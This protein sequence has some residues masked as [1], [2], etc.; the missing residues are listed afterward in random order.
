MR[1]LGIGKDNDLGSLYLRLM[2][3]GHEVKVFIE[4]E[5]SAETL[6]GMVDRVADWSAELAWLRAAGRDGAILFEAT[7]YGPVAEQLRH[8]GFQIIGSSI[9]GDRLEED[10][11]F[12]QQIMRATGM[13]V[14]ESHAF[15]SFDDGIAFVRERPARYVLKL[16]GS[17]LASGHT[18]PSELADGR[19][20]IAM[21]EWHSHRWVTERPSF[22]LMDLLDGVEVGVGAYFNGE[23]FLRPACMDWE[24][25]RFFPGD[26][27]E[28]TGEMGTL[29]TY[30]ARTR[31]STRRWGGWS[32]GS[33]RPA[34]SATSTS[35]PS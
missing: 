22:I 35:T 5:D 17:D 15:D 33:A 34:M 18:F 30:R 24:H 8:D 11:A 19:D 10:R 6:G 20:M 21:L 29:V 27:G 14:A 25:K 28:L 1:F 7:G 12:G 13:S 23:R 4:N 3:A 16:S 2:Q 9:F 32:R 31:F 26:I